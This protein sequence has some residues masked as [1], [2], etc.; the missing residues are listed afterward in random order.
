MLVFSS[1]EEAIFLWIVFC[2]TALTKD[3]ETWL[4]TCLH[5]PPCSYGANELSVVS[6]MQNWYG[7]FTGKQDDTRFITNLLF[8]WKILSSFTLNLACQAVE[9]FHSF[10]FTKSDVITWLQ[11]V[12]SVFQTTNKSCFLLQCYHF[13]SFPVMTSGRWRDCLL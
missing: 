6:Q 13:Q 10:H 2:C 11:T 8:C 1:L 7:F 12:H 9:L 4:F 3:I 5:T